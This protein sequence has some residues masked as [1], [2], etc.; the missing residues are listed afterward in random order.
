MG[1]TPNLVLLGLFGL[2]NVQASELKVW[3]VSARAGDGATLGVFGWQGFSASGPLL[4]K[5][6][7]RLSTHAVGFCSILGGAAEE[8]RCKCVGLLCARSGC[9]PALTQEVDYRKAA[10]HAHSYRLGKRTMIKTLPAEPT[11]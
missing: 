3:K 5:G 10:H 8:L 2:R 6:S 1:P 9:L 7:L 11:D 4:S